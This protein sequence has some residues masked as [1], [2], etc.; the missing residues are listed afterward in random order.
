MVCI[1]RMLKNYKHKL[2]K[3][4]NRKF[5]DAFGS[6]EIVLNFELRNNR[7]D[8]IFLIGTTNLKHFY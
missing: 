3:S 6:A 8:T 5:L 7:A 2:L 1:S 4:R